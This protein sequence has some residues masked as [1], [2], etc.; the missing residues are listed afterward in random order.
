MPRQPYWMTRLYLFSVFML[1]V[2][3]SA[4]MP[5]Y[6]RYYVT[7]L[8]FLSWLGNFYLTHAVHYV[9]ATVFLVLTFRLAVLWLGRWK[10]RFELDGW[11]WTRVGLVALLIITGLLR[12]AKNLPDISFSPMQVLLFD[13]LHLIGAMFYGLTAL[14]ARFAGKGSYL[15]KR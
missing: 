11:G 10:K 5:L 2:S 3:G 7:E 12:T 6:K 4:Q 9:F 14:G 15:R 8:P 1:A 13:W